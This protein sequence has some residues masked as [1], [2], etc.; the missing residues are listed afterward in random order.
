MQALDQSFDRSE[1]L[2]YFP[3]AFCDDVNVDVVYLLRIAS[4]PIPPLS[5]A[6]ALRS[7]TSRPHIERIRKK[8]SDG[9]QLI[10]M[11]TKPRIGMQ[12]Q[13]SK[14]EMKQ[15][16]ISD[17]GHG[18]IVEVGDSGSFCMVIQS[19]VR[20]LMNSLQSCPS[21]LRKFVCVFCVCVCARARVWQVEW[22]VPYPPDEQ[23]FSICETSRHDKYWLAVYVDK[24]RKATPPHKKWLLDAIVSPRYEYKP[25]QGIFG[26]SI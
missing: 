5:N 7:P 21:C 14:K 4:G 16:N 9:E 17:P 3:L 20:V 18:A 8:N 23:Q 19:N 24:T 2:K 11:D 26:Q 1:I 13:F 6:N 22:H 25:S 15:R 10:G 12:V